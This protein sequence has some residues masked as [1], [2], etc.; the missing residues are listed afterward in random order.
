MRSRPSKDE[1][2]TPAFANALCALGTQDQNIKLSKLWWG[3]IEKPLNISSNL[4]HQRT[5]HRMA[6]ANV[7]H[8]VKRKMKKSVKNAIEGAVANM[9]QTGF[10]VA[11]SRTKE[12]L[13]RFSK[14]VLTK[15]VCSSS[16]KNILAW[17]LNKWNLFPVFKCAF[18]QTGIKLSHAFSEQSCFWERTIR[19]I[20]QIKDTWWLMRMLIARP[21]DSKR[22]PHHETQT[23]LQVTKHESSHKLRSKVQNESSNAISTRK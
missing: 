2:A 11:E 14:T 6:S 8:A 20:P 18:T 22:M 1:P 23:L 15:M 5:L 7:S 21:R 17:N 13:F 10:A 19:M 16:L 12:A 3:S 9:L 4:P